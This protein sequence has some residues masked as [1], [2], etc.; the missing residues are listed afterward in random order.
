VWLT[1]R[2]KADARE[3]M[4][5]AVRRTNVT[6]MGFSEQGAV[7]PCYR[8]ANAKVERAA[9][10]YGCVFGAGQAEEYVRAKGMK[11]RSHGTEALK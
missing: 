6:A 8:R 3:W 7:A 10:P 11:T 1:L 9:R 4:A 2:T 5:R